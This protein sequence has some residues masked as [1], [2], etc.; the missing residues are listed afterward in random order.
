MVF[1]I[2]IYSLLEQWLTEQARER[3]WVVTIFEK[4]HLGFSH[5]ERVALLPLFSMLLC[6]SDIFSN[7]LLDVFK[8]VKNNWNLSL[9][10]QYWS[11]YEFN[12]K[13]TEF[14]LL[15]LLFCFLKMFLSACML[16]SCITDALV[17]IYLLSYLSQL[18]SV[19]LITHRYFGTQKF[20][21]D[22][23]NSYR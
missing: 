14:D 15:G 16:N 22:G 1:M 2:H 19:V 13:F 20:D 4:K 10:L 5:L 3:Q 18:Y 21:R 8:S 7:T 6:R 17:H 23:L 12:S 11:L 9:P